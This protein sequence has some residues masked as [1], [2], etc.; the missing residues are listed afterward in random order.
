MSRPTPYSELM[1]LTLGSYR[2]LKE[3]PE[4]PDDEPEGDEESNTSNNN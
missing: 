2:K 1:S 3:E 4:E